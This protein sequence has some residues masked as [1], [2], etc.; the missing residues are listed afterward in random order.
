MVKALQQIRFFDVNSGYQTLSLDET[1]VTIINIQF[2]RNGKKKIVSLLDNFTIG[3]W[4]VKKYKHFG[5]I[6]ILK[7]DNYSKFMMDKLLCRLAVKECDISSNGNNIVS[8]FEDGKVRLWGLLYSDKNNT[9]KM[10]YFV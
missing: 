4:D 6:Q 10:L 7:C 8:S 3:I 9:F 5:K 2:S 1:P